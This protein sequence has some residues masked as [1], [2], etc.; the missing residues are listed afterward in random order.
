MKSNENL[1]LKKIIIISVLIIMCLITIQLLWSFFHTGSVIIYT[2]DVHN[3]IQLNAIVNKNG[4]GSSQ[5]S[6]SSEGKL[7]TSLKIGEYIATV[8][9]NNLYSS[10]LIKISFNKTSIYKINLTNPIVSEPVIST[11]SQDIAASSNKF[12]YLNTG[13]NNIELVDSSNNKYTISPSKFFE[14]VK[15]ANVN[16]GIAQDINQQLYQVN[17]SIVKAINLPFNNYNNTSYSVSNNK[18]LYVANNGNIYVNNGYNFKIIYK[19][20]SSNITLGA[21]SDKVAIAYNTNATNPDNIN[22]Q[23][24]VHYNDGKT[25]KT[26]AQQTIA[27][28]I[29]SPNNQLLASLGKSSINIYD[30]SLRNI[31]TIPSIYP[32]GNLVWENSTTIAYSEKTNIWSFN[33]TTGKNYVIANTDV[34]NIIT[35]IYTSDS[36]DYIYYSTNSSTSSSNSGIFRIGLFNQHPQQLASQ[37]QDILP[38]SLGDSTLSLVN[39]GQPTTILISPLFPRGNIDKNGLVQEAQ[40]TLQQYGFDIS[41]LKF[42]VQD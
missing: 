9:H 25:V 6:L 39:F 24:L 26:D 33:L 28:L 31:A 14:S 18:Q 22:T 27:G 8:S 3:Q 41:T 15:W 20:P 10:Q 29:W 1:N 37:L 16:Y 35:S 4:N 23:I 7:N 11:V 36:K 21:A 5:Y 12:V 42:N 13:N 30:S 40:K 32:V 17:N 34:G 2:N 38:L 19:V